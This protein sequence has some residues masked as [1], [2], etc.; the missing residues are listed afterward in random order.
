[1]KTKTVRIAALAALAAGFACTPVKEELKKDVV[2]A[3]PPPKEK[4]PREIFDEGLAAFDQG[5]LEDANAAFAK[6]AEKVPDNLVLQYDLGVIDE[7]L[8]NLADAQKH[9]EAAEK[10]DPKHKPTL[11]NLGKVYRLQDKFDQAIALYEAAIKEPGNEFD[12]E[13]NN[14]LTVALRLAKKFDKAEAVA[15]KVLART[16]DNPD[17]YK[18]LALIYFDQGKF[19]LAEFIS[20]NAKKLDAKDPGVYNNLGLIYLKLDER[21]LALA[22]FQKAIA[23]NA[24]F[25]PGLFNIGAMALSYRDY[26]GAEKVFSQVTR[27][28]PGS[29]E[30]FLAYA[31]ALDGQKGRDP[32]KGLAAGQAFERVL[33]L[34]ADQPDAICGAGWAYSA[35]KAG[36]DKALSFLDRCKALPGTAATDQQLIDTKVKG[37]LAMQKT[38]APAAAPPAEKEKPKPAAAQGASLLDKVTS[39]EAAPKEG[40]PAK[41]EK[42][43]E[44][45]PEEK[46]KDEKPKDAAPAPPPKA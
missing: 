43:P 1:M 46:P 19:R 18:N 26:A 36:W 31:W 20:A 40:E 14:N 8:G 10:L 23:L 30:S 25:A 6:V 28:D 5:K 7:R 32:K 3:P 16:K 11:L 17:A 21:R 42:A 35:D 38:G 2:E 24:S 33:A 29:Y 15:K 37:I 12:V 44:K 22:Q 41:D 27:L 39:D 13:L 45:A 4:S 34:K 9:Y